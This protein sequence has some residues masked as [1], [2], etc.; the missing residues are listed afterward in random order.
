MDVLTEYVYLGTVVVVV[1][2]VVVGFVVVLYG[3]K[4]TC[5]G[6]G[7]CSVFVFGCC[8]LLMVLKVSPAGFWNFFLKYGASVRA[9]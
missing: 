7:L 2:V 8:P 4:S 6:L 1:V 9:L 5:L 3:W